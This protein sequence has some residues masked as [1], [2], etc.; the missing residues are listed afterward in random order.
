[1]Y[2]T[3]IDR[4]FLIEKPPVHRVLLAVQE[5]MQYDP[6]YKFVDVKNLNNIISY[7]Q[8]RYERLSDEEVKKIVYWLEVYTPQ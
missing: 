1:M 5:N 7:I 6:E 4:P 2:V 3:L 8:T